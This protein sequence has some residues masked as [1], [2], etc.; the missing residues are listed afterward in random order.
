MKKHSIWTREFGKS[1]VS[2]AL[3]ISLQS[4]ITIGVNMIDNIMV[5]SLGENAI[6][7]ASLSNQFF[8]LFYIACMGLA[9]G[10]SIMTARYSLRASCVC[11]P[12]TPRSL[13]RAFCT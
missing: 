12:T 2:I 9:M 8:N 11:T 7:G 10:G 6:S 1:V 13:P 4:L 5:G 3:P